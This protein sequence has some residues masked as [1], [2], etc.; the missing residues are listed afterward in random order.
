MNRQTHPTKITALY[1]R[2]SRDDE[3]QGESNSITNQKKILADY[4]ER[5]GFLNCRHFSDDGVSGTTFERK[6]FKEMIA[7]I[8]AG[9]VGAVI[10]KDMSRIGRDYLQV[11]FYTEI[12]FRQK[13]VRFIAVSN[14]IDSANGE[15]SEFAPFL[16]IMSEWYARDASRKLK[17]VYQSKGN[18]G[19]RITN[20]VIYG[21]LKDPND[22]SKWVIDPVA[23]VVVRRIFA[24]TV[25]GKGPCQIARLLE[26]D[27]V[28]T[29][30]VYQSKLGIGPRRNDVVKH[31]CRWGGSQVAAMLK[32]PE[33]MGHT[34]NFRTTKE[35]YKDKRQTPNPQADWLIFEDTHE[36]II[37][38]VTWQTAQRCRTVKR[39]TDTMGESN[40]LTGL[41]YCSDCGRRL[42][43]HRARA[44]EHT[45]PNGNVVHLSARDEYVCQCYCNPGAAVPD[46]SMHFIMSKTA[47]ALILEAIQRTTDF[48][49]N[50]EAE[51]V[52]LIR[53]A[54]ILRQSESAKAHRRQIN[55][56]ERRTAELDTLFR[57]T[58][59]DF[60]AGRLTE[61]RFEQLSQGYESEQGELET[62]TAKLR[63]ELEQFE[64]DTFRADKFM[65]L[66]K[67]YTD[68]SELTPAMLHEFV[69]KVIVF[70]ADKSSGKREQRVDIYLNYIG[71]F[72]VPAEGDVVD[73]EG[74]ERRAKWREYKRRER[75]EKK[76]AGIAE[77]AQA[78]PQE[79]KIA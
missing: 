8:E 29:A 34:V 65:E 26:A 17:A 67:R 21:Y 12:F 37:D 48:A 28:E 2:L 52:K 42:F 60:S 76:A 64:A 51:F 71:Q 57:K 19:K 63:E 39:R 49:R 70:E 40:P 18:S 27:G 30:G 6:G 4:A 1:S 61:K 55:K 43:N 38:P 73:A 68:F 20:N 69:E 14:N 77:Q 47:N 16:N 46:C 44:R 3:L 10:V 22:K 72:V 25:E 33:Y 13:G 36:A 59:E 56:N 58:Y 75:A 53:E 62:Q 66:A 79:Q 5:N 78:N 11:G 32:K 41:L 31:P 54:S 45:K 7:A 74:E 50:N 9:A 23:A 35:S 15:S 24:L